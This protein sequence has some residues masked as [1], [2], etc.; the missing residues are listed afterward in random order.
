MNPKAHREDDPIFSQRLERDGWQLKDAW[1]IENRGYPKL[2]HTI[3]LEV[4]EKTNPNRT[5]VIQLTQSIECLDY[6]EDSGLRSVKQFLVANIARA[7]WVDWDRQGRWVFLRDGKIFA[8]SIKGDSNFV[9]KAA[10]RSE[11]VET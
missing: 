2:F 6:S 4:R 1:Q 10:R 7:S 9:E 8:A 11:Y 5:H 3:Q